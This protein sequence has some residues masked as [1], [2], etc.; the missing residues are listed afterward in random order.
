MTG[1]LDRRALNRALLARQGLLAREATPA[2]DMVARLAGLQTQ[3]PTAGHLALWSRLA[4]YDPAELDALL[5]RREVVRVTLMRATKHLVTAADALAWRA[6]HEPVLRRAVRGNFSAALDGLDLDRLADLALE[7][8]GDEALTTTEL[9]RRLA[10]HFEDRDPLGLGIA[11]HL[12]HPY[13]Q[14]P[15]RGLWGRGGAALN[16][17]LAR[18]LG[19]TPSAD[20]APDELVR[21]YL[22]AF[23][24]ASVMDAQAWCGITKLRDAFERLRPQLVTF[25]GPDGAELF[26]LPDAPRPPADTPAPVRLLPVYDNVCLAYADRSRIVSDAHRKTILLRGWIDDGFVLADGFAKATWR[27]HRDRKRSARLVVTPFE[28]L[29]GVDVVPEGEAFLAFV[30]RGEAELSVEVP[31]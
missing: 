27:V 21:R 23:G 29:G 19:A 14:P 28:D 4:D 15:P 9:G 24:P 20:P 26:D 30:A 6:A 31:G 11:A 22:A 1:V 5:E 16:E 12:A 25:E 18:W 7:L 17:P 13:V 3:N 10:E 2:L 8:A